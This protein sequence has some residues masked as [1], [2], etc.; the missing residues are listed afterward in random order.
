MSVVSMPNYNDCLSRSPPK[1]YSSL[2]AAPM[3]TTLLSSMI[4]SKNQNV[5]RPLACTIKPGN[6]VRNVVVDQAKTFRI[7]LG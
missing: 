7:N 5:Y 3:S 6:L 4:K 1:Y 2:V